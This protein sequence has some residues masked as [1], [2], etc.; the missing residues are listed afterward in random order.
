VIRTDYIRD[1]N[2]ITSGYAIAEAITGLLVFG[3]IFVKLNPFRESMFF[4]SVIAFLMIYMI[5]LIRDL[6]NPFGYG[7]A[8][9]AENVSLKPLRDLATRL[10]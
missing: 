7:D 3:L 4:V 9:S 10:K 2:F 5:M 1:T 6:D 8:E